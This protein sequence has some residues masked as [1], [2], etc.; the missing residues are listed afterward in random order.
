MR[1]DMPTPLEHH[2]DQVK[3]YNYIFGL[4]KT[5]LVYV[6]PDRVTQHEVSGKASQEEMVRRL[7]EPAAPRYPWECK[8]CPFSVLCPNKAAK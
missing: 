7:V 3:I 6:S 4:E 1:G 2:L 8:Y 5:I